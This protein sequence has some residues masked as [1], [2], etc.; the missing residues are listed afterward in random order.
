MNARQALKLSI[1][2]GRLVT[3]SYLEDLTDEEMLHRPAAG[4]NHI[5][6]QLGHLIVSEHTH[7]ESVC[8]GAMPPLP[9]GFADKYSKETSTSDDAD[10]F[11]NKETLLEVYQQQRAATLQALDRLSDDD[12][13]QAAP[14]PI[15]AYAPNVGAVFEMQGSHYLMHAGQWAVIRRQL[16]RRPLF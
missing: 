7:L 8:P 13:D 15:R 3:L 1:N 6:W 11:A 5:N 9:A 10:Q 2:M 14:E 4:C 16:G 12:L